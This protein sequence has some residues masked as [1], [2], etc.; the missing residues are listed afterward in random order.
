MTDREMLENILKEI[1]DL[2]RFDIIDSEGGDDYDHRYCYDGLYV[3]HYEI[4]DILKNLENH[5]NNC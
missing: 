1:K 2:P 3:N 5:L 4:E